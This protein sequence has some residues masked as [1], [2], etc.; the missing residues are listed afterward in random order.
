[1]IINFPQ[2]E[3]NTSSRRQ[4][5]FPSLFLSGQ[6]LPRFKVLE[7]DTNGTLYLHKT[8][9]LCTREIAERLTE[10]KYQLAEPNNLG[11]KLQ[12]LF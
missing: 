5:V 8:S 9:I 12:I 4:M 3:D 7:M 11:N 10:G 6:D 1:M 2:H